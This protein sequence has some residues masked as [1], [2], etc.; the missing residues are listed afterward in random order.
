MKVVAFNGS[1]REDGNTAKLV[2]NVFSEL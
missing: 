1:P 2:K